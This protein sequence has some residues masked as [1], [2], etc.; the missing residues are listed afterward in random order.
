MAQDNEVAEGRG[1]EGVPRIWA[2]RGGKHGEL[3]DLFLRRNTLAVGWPKVGDLSHLPAERLR[4]EQLVTAHYPNERAG[5]VRNAAGQLY[6][7]VFEMRV[8]D[9]VVYP[10]KIGRLLHVGRLVGGY[11]YDAT[12]PLVFPHRRPVVWLGDLDRGQ[13]EQTALR[14]LGSVLTLFRLR[15]PKTYEAVSSIAR[16]GSKRGARESEP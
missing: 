15:H 5:Y 10:S 1:S 3:Q 8:G 9:L 4:F 16:V 7:F 6:K 12:E 2:V 11:R 14:E 13:L